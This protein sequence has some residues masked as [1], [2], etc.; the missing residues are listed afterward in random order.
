MYVGFKP[1]VNKGYF[2]IRTLTEGEKQSQAVF[3]VKR[4]FYLEKSELE[5][6]VGKKLY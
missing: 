2:I 5:R 3:A 4:H 1:D 6:R